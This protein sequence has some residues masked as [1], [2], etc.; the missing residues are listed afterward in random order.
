MRMTNFKRWLTVNP[1]RY[2][3]T[4]STRVR[5]SVN[6][7]FALSEVFLHVLWEDL[8][9]FLLLYFLQHFSFC[10][11]ILHYAISKLLYF[12]IC[13]LTTKQDRLWL[14]Q[15]VR[16]AGKIHAHC[17]GLQNQE[18]RQGKGKTCS[19]SFPVVDPAEHCMPKQPNTTV[20]P[21]KPCPRPGSEAVAS[22]TW[23]V[24]D[25]VNNVMH[26]S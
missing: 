6:C 22:E 19:N 24:V 20:P 23:S 11:N 5:F 10:L 17:S 9:L 21:H 18:N 1:R 14:W 8:R 26:Q 12:E 3:H 13:C 2:M 25:N 4:V 7:C 16:A 15:T